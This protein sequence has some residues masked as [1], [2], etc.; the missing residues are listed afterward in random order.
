[1]TTHGPRR[2]TQKG[3]KAD[4]LGATETK[5]RAGRLAVAQLR[6]QMQRRGLA[7]AA[8]GAATG[9]ETSGRALQIQMTK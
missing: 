5:N 6:C 4:S 1:M 3:Q 2:G 9:D 7:V 8:R